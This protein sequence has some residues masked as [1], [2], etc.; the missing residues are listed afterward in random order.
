MQLASL[1][2][3]G[4]LT[5]SELNGQ[6][7][8][9][10]ETSY[11]FVWVKGEIS[12]FRIPASGH[13]YFTLKD[14]QSQMRAVFF[15][16]QHR[17]LRFV[18]ESGLQVLCQGRVSVYEPRG[19]YQ[20]IVEIM[21]P[22]GVGALQ[23]AFE[24]L[25]RKL[26][27]E[28]LFD[29]T[30]KRPLPL[31]PQH[32]A[33]VTS[34]TGAAV[35][36]ILKILERSPYPLSITVL[37]VRVQGQDASMEI[38]AAIDLANFLAERFKWDILIVGRGGGSLEDLWPFNEEAVARAISRSTLPV[39]SAVGHEIDF[40]ISDL[41]A[42]LRAPTPTAAAEWIVSQLEQFRRELN[43]HRDRI[44]QIIE[45]RL[46]AHK[47]K[48]EFLE[49]RL[50]DP[51]RRIEDLRLFVDERFE[52]L[53]LAFMRRVE[54]LRTMQMHLTEKL[55]FCHPLKNIQ[56][57]RSLLNQS[58]K[59]LALH[60]NKVLDKHRFRLQKYALQLESLSPL[61]VLARGYSITYRQPDGKLVRSSEDVEPGQDVRIRL[62][63]GSLECTVRKT[64]KE[65]APSPLRMRCGKEEE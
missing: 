27:A 22:Q 53:H 40:T 32:I 65:D 56:Q 24:Q 34:S 42:D 44:R 9:L 51:K 29:E 45:Q 5:V 12:N 41:A 39:I 52:R 10:L 58:C 7:K 14:E 1:K 31:C 38:A 28:G 15:R 18:P 2:E 43:A 6:I 21:E 35:Q 57:Y 61:R 55:R 23:L 25:K 8:S 20:L 49:K 59:E 17:T 13:Y 36:D 16:G 47:Q 37:P 48:L 46:E 50:I 64:V 4:V 60:H 30:V 26:E 54:R 63:Q 62:A 33:I 11:R 3:P 19:E